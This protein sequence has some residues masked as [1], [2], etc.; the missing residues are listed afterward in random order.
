MDYILGVQGRS[1]LVGYGKNFPDRPH[2]RAASCSLVGECGWDA[3]RNDVP[4]PQ[5]LLGAL[6]GGPDE[7]DV[8]VNNRTDYVRNEVALDYNAGITAISALKLD[9]ERGNVG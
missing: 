4:N 7:F 1:F 2:H 3:Y 6:V 8:F 5:V 9:L